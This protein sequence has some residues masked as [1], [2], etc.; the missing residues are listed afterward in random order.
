MLPN[1][2]DLATLSRSQAQAAAGG[3]ALM[4][5]ARIELA[6]LDAM[7]IN[8]IGAASLEQ[9]AETA[10]SVAEQLVSLRL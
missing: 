9:L 3:E 1:S 7:L 2:A 6:A 5:D 8:A 10:E 4:A